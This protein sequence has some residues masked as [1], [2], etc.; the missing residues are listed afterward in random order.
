MSPK[1][2]KRFKKSVSDG[3]YRSNFDESAFK[4]GNKLKHILKLGPESSVNYGKILP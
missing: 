1:K 3:S 4:N 2:K